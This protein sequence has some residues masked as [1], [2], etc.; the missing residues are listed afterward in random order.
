M[1]EGERGAG[2]M[3]GENG[4]QEKWAAATLELSSVWQCSTTTTLATAYP[5]I[6]WTDDRT[7]A[8]PADS[9]RPYFLRLRGD[10]NVERDKLR[11][12]E[13]TCAPSFIKTLKLISRK[14][15]KSL[16]GTIF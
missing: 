5:L 1:R 6:M 2:G 11:D 13:F 4:E 9:T 14:R 10:I 8:P 15:G 12:S 7:P 3:N 16:A